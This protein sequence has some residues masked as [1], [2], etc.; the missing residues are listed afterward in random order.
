MPLEKSATQRRIAELVD[1]HAHYTAQAEQA[2]FH[3]EALDLLRRLKVYADRSAS[4]IAHDLCVE[5]CE[6]IAKHTKKE[7]A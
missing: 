1:P 6:F 5:A 7:A 2:Q 4:P 3:A